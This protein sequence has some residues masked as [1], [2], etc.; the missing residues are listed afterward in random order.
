MLKLGD[1]ELPMNLRAQIFWVL[2]GSVFSLD[3]RR[4]RSTSSG[5]RLILPPACDTLGK[6]VN[7]LSDQRQAGNPTAPRLPH[8]SEV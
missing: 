2:N 6:D 3:T 4:A 1:T 7:E 5:Q 8:P